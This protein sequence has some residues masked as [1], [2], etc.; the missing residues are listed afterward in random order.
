VATWDDVER[1]ALSLPGTEERSAYGHRAWRV[2]DKLFVWERPLRKLEL[3]EELAPK[4]PE[5]EVLA[6]RVESLEKKSA[7]LEGDPGVYFTT[8]HFDGAPVVLVRLEA[9]STAALEQLVEDAW[10]SRAPARLANSYLEE[11]RR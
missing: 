2:R 4:L 10:L 7:L 9:I 5:G 6:A 8:S 11:R 3:L 1:I